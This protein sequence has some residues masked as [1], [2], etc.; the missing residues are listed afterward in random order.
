MIRTCLPWYIQCWPMDGAGVR[1]QP[2]EARGVGSRGG[3]DR[4]VL[5]R[6]RLL[7]RGLDARDGGAL[8]ADG[9]VDAAN[10]LLRVARLPGLLLVDDRV[11]ADRGLA[12]LA[13]TDDQLTLAATD[14]GHR[15]DG[16]DAGL[17]RLGHRLTLQH[18]GRLQLQG[19]V[20]V[21][22]DVTE[23]VDRLAER[24]DDATEEAVADRHGQ[25]LARPADLLA[26][27]DLVV[28]TED[29]RTDVA[30]LEVQRDAEDAAGEL[31]QLVGHRAAEG[32]RRWRCRRRSRR[33]Y[34][35]L[36]G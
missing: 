23:A 28:V 5:E 21:G 3:D 33:R 29:D 14:R 19:A 8:L 35:P 11:D 24:V 36:P 18:G 26:L 31:E 7:Q 30:D 13:V 22:D 16:L 25:D 2:L 32:L 34:R 10:L 4:R 6:A 12:G 1:R 17:H 20:V 9:D 15:V 27:F